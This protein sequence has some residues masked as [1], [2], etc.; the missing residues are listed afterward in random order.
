[1]EP[2]GDFS[3]LTPH[4]RRFAKEMKFSSW[5]A[6]EDGSWQHVLLPGPMNFTIWA[7][8][9][10]VY[11]CILL[12]LRDHDA[13]GNLQPVATM[14]SLENYYEAFAL[15]CKENPEA[16]YLCVVAEDRCRM[17]HFPRLWR[18]LAEELGHAPTW[19]QVFDRAATDDKYWDREVRRPAISDL[20]RTKGNRALSAEEEVAAR[21]TRAAEDLKNGG[22]NLAKKLKKGD[23]RMSPALDRPA[24]PVKNPLLGGGGDHPR[25]DHR[26]RYTTTTDGR[27]IC[28]NFNTGKCKEPCRA[29]RAHLC[30]HCMQKHSIKGCDAF[31]NLQ[32][33]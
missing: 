8:C 19:T 3:L 21:V 7:S 29:K 14:Q 11:E 9:W 23:Q 12:M 5:I 26:G 1:M 31:K 24:P 25:K 2:Y 18:K 20:V 32:K 22:G 15:L 28:F 4:G 10:R 27:P 17:E 13:Y 33:A 30:Q 16:W 6:M